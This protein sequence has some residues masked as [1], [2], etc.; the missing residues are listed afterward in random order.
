MQKLF[1][2]NLR[3]ILRVLLVTWNKTLYHLQKVNTSVAK[4]HTTFLVKD[5]HNKKLQFGIAR[6]GGQ[7]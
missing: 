3:K 6:G 4:I 5:L 7:H 1:Q 2:I